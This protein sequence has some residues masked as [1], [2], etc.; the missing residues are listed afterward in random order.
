MNKFLTCFWLIFEWKYPSIMWI[1]KIRPISKFAKYD[2]FKN[3]QNIIDS[4]ICKYLL[5][6]PSSSST[7]KKKKGKKLMK[8]FDFVRFFLFLDGVRINTNRSD[9]AKSD[10]TILVTD[11]CWA[12]KASYFRQGL[13]FLSCPKGGRWRKANRLAASSSGQKRNNRQVGSVVIS[14]AIKNP[15]VTHWVIVGWS[16]LVSSPKVASRVIECPKIIK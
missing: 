9:L 14:R 16:G 11:F 5:I 7:S 13:F 2:Q 3:L 1:R 4:R 8:I 6:F 12:S 10:P 15:V